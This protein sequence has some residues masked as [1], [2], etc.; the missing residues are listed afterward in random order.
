MGETQRENNKTNAE[1][2][3]LEIQEINTWNVPLKRDRFT[4][5]PN[6]NPEELLNMIKYC[7]DLWSYI[8]YAWQEIQS[9]RRGIDNRFYYQTI[10]FNLFMLSAI[11]RKI[12]SDVIGN[13]KNL[14]DLRDNIAHMDE[15]LKKP[16]NFVPLNDIKDGSVLNNHGGGKT[17]TMA[18]TGMHIMGNDT[19][20]SPLGILDNI[21]FSTLKPT[22]KKSKYNRFVSYE[23]SIEHLY[24]IQSNLLTL[25]DKYFIF[26]TTQSRINPT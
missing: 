22:Q 2:I 26:P 19:V 10:I 7:C 6:V 13:N 18:M 17:Y 15:K 11:T 1:E 12:G 21:V 8:Y 24:E 4:A 3:V 14:K 25:L 5:N 23:I 20:A 16:L 9:K